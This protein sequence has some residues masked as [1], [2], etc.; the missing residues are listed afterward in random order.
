M[1]ISRKLPV[2]RVGEITPGQTKSFRFGIAQG[3]A[4]NDG[5]TIKAFVNKCTHMGGPVELEK[6]KDG[7]RLRCRWHE[8]AFDPATGKVLEGQAPAGS[9]LTPISLTIE[10]DQIMALLELPPDPFDF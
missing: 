1:P 4:Y 8:A 10:D 7:P 9:L 3:I 6:G 5:G 2:A